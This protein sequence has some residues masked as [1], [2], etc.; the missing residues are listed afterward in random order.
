[1]AILELVIDTIVECILGKVTTKAMDYM[2]KDSEMKAKERA[3]SGE[4]D[5]DVAL[6]KHK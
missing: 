3:E 4:L 1:M 2:K 6:N 5:P